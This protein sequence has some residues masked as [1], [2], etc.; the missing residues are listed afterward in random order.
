MAVREKAK[1]ILAELKGHLPFTL[2][3]AGLGIVFML[4]FKNIGHIG[5]YRL[6][7]IFHPFHVVLSAIVTASMLRL[8][9][10][11]KRF[12]LVLV[13]GYVGS[14]GIATLSDIVIPHISSKIL[15]LDV[16]GHAE[17]HNQEQEG[18]EH[19]RERIHLSFIEEWYNY[20]AQG[21]DTD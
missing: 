13:I 7:S 16:P 8:H 20:I 2:F 10:E 1:H 14:V 18:D 4:I 3:G 15:G 5:S 6:F 11:K 9:T 17:I 12:L 19:H 21:S